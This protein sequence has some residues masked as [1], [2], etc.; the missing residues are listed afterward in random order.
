MTSTQAIQSVLDLTDIKSLDGASINH[1]LILANAL[2]ASVQ[3]W[4]ELAPSIYK[5]TRATFATTYP[6][7]VTCVF[8]PGGNTA[9]AEV[10]T[11]AMRGS[12]VLIAGDN[13]WNEVV[14]RS[15]VL[16]PYRG[17]ANSVNAVVYGDCWTFFDFAIERI[18]GDVEYQTGDGKIGLLSP[19]ETGRRQLHSHHSSINAFANYG[20]GWGFA[21]G[22]ADIRQIREV[23]TCYTLEPVGDSVNSGDLDATM[24]VRLD[25]IPSRGLSL[26]AMVDILP[27]T[28]GVQHVTNT[29]L[30]LPVPDERCQLTL[31]P[32]L[33]LRVANSSIGTVQ[34]AKMG[35]IQ[36][37]AA[38]ARNR[39]AMLPKVRHRTQSR[40]AIKPGH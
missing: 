13:T 21:G 4:F 2:T 34:Q 11:D 27:R 10:F 31:L 37:E 15:T 26:S 36:D 29:P 28:Y 6:Q 17:T 32:L 3:L 22:S 30:N 7:A 12:T 39:I 18:A 16:Y 23:P 20:T 25:P 14:D 9:S 38:E 1:R 19:R 33:A 24:M 35:G 8:E 40:L 5:R